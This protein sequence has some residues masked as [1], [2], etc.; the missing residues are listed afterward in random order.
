MQF[1]NQICIMYFRIKQKVSK[2]RNAGCYR[3]QLKK[4]RIS[5]TEQVITF[6]WNN[7]KTFFNVTFMTP[8]L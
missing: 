2:K 6:L 4:K 1:T 5:D 3:H 7:I 8:A